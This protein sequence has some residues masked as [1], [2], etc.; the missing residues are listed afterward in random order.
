MTSSSV[1]VGIAGDWH[2]NTRWAGKVLD[3]FAAAGIT[4]VYQVGDFGVWPGQGGID[5]LASIDARLAG[6]GQHLFVIPGNHEDYDQL[7]ALP[8]DAEGW[9]SH[10]G[11]PRIRFA[12]RGHTW[13]A[14]GTRFAALGGAGSI[15]RIPRTP[16]VSWWP[17][18]E[19]TD[20]DVATLTAN[21]AERGWD[22]IDV[23]LTHEAPAGVRRVGI[24]RGPAWLT[25]EVEHY[26]NTQ[27]IR[28]RE[29]VDAVAPFDVVHGHWH[30]WYH[31]QID[32]IR[33][34]GTQYTSVV[35]GLS[36]DGMLEHAGIAEVTPGEGIT[37]FDLLVVF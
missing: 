18:E 36:C 9:L 25:P 21:V 2:G 13:D 5:F 35:R 8:H 30:D 23:L 7:D 34:D 11:Y 22:R 10:A 12:P 6:H 32:G 27:R 28:L 19:I 16:G 20:A 24:R 17:Q 33:P 4:R 29:A 1:R 31:D 14:G 26:C 15:D 37:G 3:D